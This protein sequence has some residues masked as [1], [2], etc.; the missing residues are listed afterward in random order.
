M[1]LKI[2]ILG[3]GKVPMDLS[4]GDTTQIIAAFLTV[5]AIFF[6]YRTIKQN[7]SNTRAAIQLDCFKQYIA[8][9]QSR[10][11][12]IG[13]KSPE[14]VI[15]S[16][17]ELFDLHWMEFYLWLDNNISDNF[18]ELWLEAR[19]DDCRKDS[20]GI[21]D[22]NGVMI[23]Y[24]YAWEYILKRNYFCTD[25]KFIDFM[26]LGHEGKIK[27]ALA[28]KAKSRGKKNDYLFCWTIIFVS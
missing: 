19:F 27:E 28:I 11:E 25:Q 9:Q 1:R 8:A 15:S 3:A 16:Y 17:R 6:A 13:S 4:I 2:V 18:M 14:K 5:I 26:R 21:V 12:A 22:N 24:K 10:V 20:S 7:E 23:T